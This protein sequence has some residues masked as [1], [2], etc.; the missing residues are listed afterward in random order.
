MCGSALIQA[1]LEANGHA[2]EGLRHC[3]HGV[4]MV[5]EGAARPLQWSVHAIEK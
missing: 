2:Y 4:A 1:I 3:L 5:T